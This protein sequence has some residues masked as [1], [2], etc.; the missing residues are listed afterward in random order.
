MHRIIWALR[1]Q[2]A[3]SETDLILNWLKT[4]FGRG[5]EKHIKIIWALKMCGANSATDLSIMM[6]HCL[7]RELRCTF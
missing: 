3:N 4:K 1:M 2:G 7:E 6:T 5:A